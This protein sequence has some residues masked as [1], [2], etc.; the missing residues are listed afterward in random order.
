M[1]DGTNAALG[2][3]SVPKQDLP[4]VILA[5]YDVQVLRP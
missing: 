4:G 1:S 5:N 2:M 3:F